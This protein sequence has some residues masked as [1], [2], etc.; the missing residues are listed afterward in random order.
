MARILEGLVVDADRMR[1][2]LERSHGLV[3]SQRVLLALGQAGLPRQTAYELVQRAAMR[4]WRERRP[5]LECLTE[6]PDV[7]RRI[8]AEALKACFDP[9]WYVRHVD[10]VFRRLGLE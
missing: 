1:E 6:D 2:N 3:Y 7:T 5:F 10:A 9:A 8:G 4:A